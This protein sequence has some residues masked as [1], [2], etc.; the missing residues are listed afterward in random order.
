MQVRGTAQLIDC[1][2]CL[3]TAFLGRY[4]RGLDLSNPQRYRYNGA[5]K[6]SILYTTNYEHS[7]GFWNSCPGIAWHNG[8]MGGL[9]DACLPQNAWVLGTDQFPRYRAQRGVVNYTR[10]GTWTATRRWTINAGAS[11]L[12]SDW[13]CAG[14]LHYNRELSLAEVEQVEEWL[15]GLYKVVPEPPVL[16]EPELAW[17]ETSGFA[18]FPGR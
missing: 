9:S 17:N 15:D 1:A 5:T 18:E 7:T 3:L 13:A 11:Q 6:R 2:C 4:Q 10:T 16:G 8:W 12:P 14:L